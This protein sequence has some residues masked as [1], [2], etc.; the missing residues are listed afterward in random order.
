MHARNVY[1]IVEHAVAQILPAHITG[2]DRFGSVLTRPCLRYS[3]TPWASSWRREEGEPWGN[4][5]PLRVQ[6]RRAHVQVRG[7]G[8]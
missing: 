1:R 6:I 5:L 8:S 7:P 2:A 4:R 3:R